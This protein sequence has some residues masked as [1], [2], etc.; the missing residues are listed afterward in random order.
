MKKYIHATESRMHRGTN[1]EIRSVNSA[2]L[3]ESFAPWLEVFDE[4]TVIARVD[5]RVG[6]DGNVVE[7][8]D[9]RVHALPNYVGPLQFARRYWAVRAGVRQACSDSRS[10]YGGRI[11]GVVSSL[12]LNRARRLRAPFFAHVVG[13]A[14]AVLRTGV[15]GALGRLVASRARSA[16]RRQVKSAQAVLYV[17]DRY[18]QGKYPPAD[19]APTIARSNVAMPPDALLSGPVG[20]RASKQGHFRL[21]AVGTQEQ[22]YKGHDLLIQAVQPLA[23]RGLKVH[24]ELVGGGRFQN[25]LREFASAHGVESNVAFRGHI[26]DPVRVRQIIDDAD[27]FIMPS[28]TEGVPRALI[29]AMARAKPCLGSDAGGI[30]E[31]LSEDALFASDDV[32]SMVDAILRASNDREWMLAQAKANLSKAREIAA[33]GQDASFVAMLRVFSRDGRGR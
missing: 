26:D 1:G 6:D 30:P 13:D 18:L 27:L 3:R 8:P 11:P 19:D 22:L 17:S 7:R 14:E 20:L 10:F 24:V 16:M 5:S 29:E 33:S 9:F 28:R 4:I 31:L 15:G 21:V 2:D 32:D 23:K 12:V 25:E